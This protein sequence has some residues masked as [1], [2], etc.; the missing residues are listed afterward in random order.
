MLSLFVRYFEYNLFLDLMETINPRVSHGFL[1]W[2]RVITL[3]TG[4]VL[5][6]MR[7][8]VSL[9]ILYYKPRVYH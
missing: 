6:Y 1:F 5:L 2:V 8:K 3:D 7:N 9:N 4:I